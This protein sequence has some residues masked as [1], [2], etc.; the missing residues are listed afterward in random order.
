MKWR[1]S[2]VNVIVERGE[3]EKGGTYE[4]MGEW[5]NI[6][7]EKW[8]KD[9]ESIN[10]CACVPW[11]SYNVAHLKSWGLTNIVHFCDHKIKFV[12]PNVHSSCSSVPP[13]LFFP[14][15]TISEPGV[16]KSCFSFCSTIKLLKWIR[17]GSHFK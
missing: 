10:C 11:Q 5:Y 16:T 7:I 12:L 17:V 2:E 14:Y 8:T 6:I 4:F 1:Y 3:S 13:S 9:F 15:P